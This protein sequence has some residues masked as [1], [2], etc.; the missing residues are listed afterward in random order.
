MQVPQAATVHH[1]WASSL[2]VDDDLETLLAH[3]VQGADRAR[4]GIFCPQLLDCHDTPSHHA[5]ATSTDNESGRCDMQV[6]KLTYVTADCA[7][8]A[9][10][11]RDVV[12]RHI[13]FAA[14]LRGCE[15][16]KINALARSKDEEHL[17]DF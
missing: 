12:P 8:T 17:E 4:H 14:L 5:K 6:S 11:Q 16:R 2:E 15:R 9:Q 7:Q 1:A 10:P 3:A 13:P